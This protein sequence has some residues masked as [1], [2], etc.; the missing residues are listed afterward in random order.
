MATGVSV[1]E[2][3][4][5]SASSSSLSEDMSWNEEKRGRLRGTSVPY[6]SSMSSSGPVDT[7]G[8][9][10][11]GVSDRRC[12]NTKLRAESCVDDVDGVDDCP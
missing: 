2:D 3:R 10:E 5:V 4:V 12:E 8:S 1:M 11:I 9:E 6:G 7:G